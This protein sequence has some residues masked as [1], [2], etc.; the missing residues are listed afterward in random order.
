[1]KH[2][3]WYSRIGSCVCLPRTLYDMATIKMGM[4]L[5]RKQRKNYTSKHC[6]LQIYNLCLS[7][8]DAAESYWTMESPSVYFGTMNKKEEWTVV[9]LPLARDLCEWKSLYFECVWD[10]AKYSSY[11]PICV[12]SSEIDCWNLFRIHACVHFIFTHSLHGGMCAL[13][14]ISSNVILLCCFYSSL[15]CL[16]YRCIFF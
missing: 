9:I 3:E 4:K 10:R 15:F 6:Y 13:E 8:I 12:C 1:M 16:C 14:L 11:F 2:V 5:L 7:E